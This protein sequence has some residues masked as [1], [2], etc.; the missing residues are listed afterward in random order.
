MLRI[1]KII[2]AGFGTGYV[3][4]APGTAGSILGVVLFYLLNQLEVYWGLSW[5]TMLLV[6]AGVILF[7]TLIGVNAIKHVHYEWKH[8]A[9]AIVIDEIVGVWIAMYAMPHE[10]KYYLI[11]LILFRFFDIYKPLFI[12]S[13]D[14]MTSDW[15]VMLDDVL[16][17]IYSLIVIQIL[18]GLGII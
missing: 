4:I 9:S 7:V 5:N 8:D 1:H 15:S 13:L 6:N 16:A 10:W 18:H 2:A 12:R 14:K 11:A 17:G 3:P